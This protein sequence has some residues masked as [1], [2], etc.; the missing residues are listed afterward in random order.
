[1]CPPPS[2]PQTLKKGVSAPKYSEQTIFGSISCIHTDHKANIVYQSDDL[3]YTKD[4]DEALFKDIN[5]SLR[6]GLSYLFT[7]HMREG[8]RFSAHLLRRQGGE[9]SEKCL[10]RILFCQV[11]CES[12]LFGA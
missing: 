2:H 10:K 12:W 7:V 1:M 5:L 9:E 11:F 8:N 6:S 4:D 3:N